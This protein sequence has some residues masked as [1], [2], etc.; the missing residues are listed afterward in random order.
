VVV[1]AGAG[2]NA[3]A[4]GSAG[5]SAAA[6]EAARR[7]EHAAAALAA[8]GSQ[9]RVLDGPSATAALCRAVDPYQPTDAS[10]PRAT[11]DTPV[12]AVASPGYEALGE[13]R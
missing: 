1:R 5:T 10:W 11:P 4:H 3:P 13:D 12:T 8:L 6:A 7:A 2:P 9:T